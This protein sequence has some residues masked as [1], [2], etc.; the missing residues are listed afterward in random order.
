VACIGGGDMSEE[1]FD[2]V[3]LNGKF[4]KV[5][6]DL[7]QNAYQKRQYVKFESTGDIVKVAYKYKD[8]IPN[9]NEN[10]KDA[11]IEF[12]PLGQS[13][14]IQ[15]KNIYQKQNMNNPYPDS[16]LNSYTLFA[17]LATDIISPFHIS[18]DA[19]GNGNIA[20][21]TGGCHGYN[22]DQ[23]GAA[24][25]RQISISVYADGK[26]LT[27]GEEKYA[28]VINMI[29]EQ[30]VQGYNT[31]QPDGLGREILAQTIFY[32]M[33]DGCIEI[34]TR[35]KA[36]EAITIELYYGLQNIWGPNTP[37]YNGTIHYVK[38]DSTARKPYGVSNSGIKS[39]YN[40]VWRHCVRNGVNDIITWL[41]RS[42]GLGTL[43]NCGDNTPVAF[44]ES[45]GKTYF[46]MVKDTWV[47]MAQNTAVSWHGGITF[48][49]A[50]TNGADLI[51]SICKDNKV[52]K[53]VD[54]LSASTA[55]EYYNPVDMMKSDIEESV[56]DSVII[57]ISNDFVARFY[58]SAGYGEYLF[59]LSELSQIPNGQCVKANAT[60]VQGMAD[61]VFTSMPLAGEDFD[62]RKM[63]DNVTNN[64]RLTC[65][66][67]GRY[68]I[69]GQIVFSTNANGLRSASIKLN[70][71]TFIA[72]Q[73]QP[74]AA[75]ETTIVNVTTICQLA[76]NDYVELIGYQTSGGVL[77][78]SLAYPTYLSMVKVG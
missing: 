46:N 59:R 28:N 35:L 55:Y 3:I 18:A 31:K 15:I 21:F 70:N 68:L 62:T 50:I 40:N 39:T 53:V 43:S 26:K 24:T 75:S 27:P 73:K 54:F 17:G 77:N 63:H 66:A 8:Y 4:K 30:A 41:D 9:L 42:Y 65:K 56:R 57:N 67:V 13:N 20:A 36:L 49:N 51:S 14:L 78:T 2:S 74:A 60:A 10:G 69:N 33:I 32:S 23:T 1:L 47:H 71:A 16:D 19:N 72:T 29:L 34:N 61:S 38:G 12:A 52:W 5:R 58:E 76:V 25:A 7:A 64:T 37:W 6:A 48:K 11:Y 45:Y 44:T 22:G